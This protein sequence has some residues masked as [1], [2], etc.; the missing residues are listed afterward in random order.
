MQPTDLIRHGKQ[1]DNAAHRN[2]EKEKEQLR[3]QQAQQAAIKNAQQHADKAAKETKEPIPSPNYRR[4]AEL[5]VQEENEEKKK[6]PA[7]KGLEKFKLLEKMGE[8]VCLNLGIL[9]NLAD[10]FTVVE[11]SLM[12]TKRLT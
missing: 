2:K 8:Y 10:G 11:R 4:E 3:A 6:M 9:Y 12:S 7:Y 5:I 1:H